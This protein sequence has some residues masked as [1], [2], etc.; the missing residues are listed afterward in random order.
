MEKVLVT[1]CCGFVGSNLSAELLK[2]G[3]SVLG[4]DN[5][6]QG[7]IESI[8]EI[9][10][11]KNFEFRKLDILDFDSLKKSVGKV[12]K[13]VHLAAFK[14]PR[15]GNSYDTLIVNS[16]GT[17]NC[18]KLAAENNCKIVFASTS[19]IYGKNPSIPFNEESDSVIGPT[20]V[21][22]WS[23][24]I[25]KLFDEQLCYAYAE[26]FNIPVVIIRYF[27]GYG[28]C[29]KLSWW[30]GPQTVFIE[31]ILK[32][33]PVSIHGNGKQTR[34]FCYV[35]DMV[36]ATVKAME[37]DKAKN[38]AFNIG[39]DREISI[40]ELAELIHMLCKTGKKL[41]LEFVPYSSFGKYEDVMQRVPDISKAKKLLG[42]QPKVSLE[43][44]LKKTI[45]WQKNEMGVLV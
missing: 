19:D 6:S 38:Q 14:I 34:S 12:D 40:I 43:E 29:G 26:K 37:S 41:K 21:K 8:N 31:K 4:V 17:E 32:N 33:E 30:S 27:G 16:H 42:W 20:N 22:R 1:G 7:N 23:Y 3:Y 18:L 10:S 13:I 5:L 11:N 35:S 15:Y 39:S 2:K 25:S 36:D 45:E 9:S 24:A 44:G 28:P